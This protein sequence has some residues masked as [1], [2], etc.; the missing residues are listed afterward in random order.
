M[1]SKAVHAEVSRLF[2]GVEI[3]TR[4]ELWPDGASWAADSLNRSAAIAK[5]DLVSPYKIGQGNAPP[6]TMLTFFK[7]CS[8]RVK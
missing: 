1:I 7:L 2:P 6:S 3:P 8:Y 5:P 4:D